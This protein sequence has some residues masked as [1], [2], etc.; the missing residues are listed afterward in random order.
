MA[1][2][3]ASTTL[4]VVCFLG[5]VYLASLV[6]GARAAEDD[7]RR[8]QT[9]LALY[10]RIVL[11]KGLLPATAISF[12]LWI[13]IDRLTAAASRGLLLRALVIA[14]CTTVAAVAVAATLMP[15]AWLELPAV[16]YTGTGNFIATTLQLAAGIAA[17]MVVSRE[18]IDRIGSRSLRDESGLHRADT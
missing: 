12:L 1:W 17:A 2:I 6:A 11:L 13:G 18:A 9:A 15:S 14:G 10:A 5:Y 16:H 8:L 7:V 3:L 4:L